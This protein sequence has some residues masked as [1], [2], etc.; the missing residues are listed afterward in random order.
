MD[1]YA[2]T[3]RRE[4]DLEGDGTAAVGGLWST[5]SDLCRWAHHLASLEA[6]HQ[7]Q[8]MEDAEGWTLGRGLGLQLIRQ[9]DRVC[10]GSCATKPAAR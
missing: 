4:P 6:L 2:R 10:C 8:V 3:L 5:P 9:G 1:P 7:L